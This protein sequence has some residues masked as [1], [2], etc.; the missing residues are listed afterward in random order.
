MCGLQVFEQRP[1]LVLRLKKISGQIFS[2]F[3]FLLIFFD[4]LTQSVYIPVANSCFVLVGLLMV[5]MEQL[6]CPKSVGWTIEDSFPQL[7]WR[8][9]KLHVDSPRFTI[10]TKASLTRE[11][12]GP[13]SMKKHLV[14]A[15]GDTCKQ[16]MFLFVDTVNHPKVTGG[17]GQVSGIERRQL[18]CR[19]A[20]PHAFYIKT[21]RRVHIA[22]ASP[23]RNIGYLHAA[24]AA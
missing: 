13:Y 9:L 23:K 4:D 11:C 21:S 24:P 12:C 17:Q 14:H 15:A 3:Q 19:S 16:Y 22:A 20:P 1:P 5:K 7:L 18:A 8:Y 2:T 10:G 6:T